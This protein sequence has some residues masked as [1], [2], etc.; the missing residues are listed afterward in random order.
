MLDD[1]D[2]SFGSSIFV[3]LEVLPK[4]IYNGFKEDWGFMELFLQKASNIGL[5]IAVNGHFRRKKPA[6]KLGLGALDALHITVAPL[7]ESHRFILR[8]NRKSFCIGLKTSK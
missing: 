2:R 1:P 4:A 6:E 5:T 7:D 8:R 3:E